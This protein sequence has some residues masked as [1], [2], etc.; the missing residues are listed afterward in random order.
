MHLRRNICLITGMGN[1]GLAQLVERQFCKLDV[2]SS[3][4]ATGTTQ[5]KCSYSVA[6]AT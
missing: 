5:Q 1:A 2:V 3:I 4:L 6:S